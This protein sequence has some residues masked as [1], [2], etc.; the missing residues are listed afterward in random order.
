MQSS[1]HFK[2]LGSKWGPSQ[3]KGTSGGIVTFSFPTQNIEG[4]EHEFDSFMSDPIFQA[5]VMDGFSAW[6]N[7]ANIKFLE[8]PDSE[9]IDIRIGWKDIDGENGILGAATLPSAGPLESVTIALDQNEEWFVGGDAPADKLDFSAVIT[10]EIGHAIGVDHPDFSGTLMS[11]GYNPE[12]L[13]IQPDDQDA[14]VEIYGENTIVKSEV[15]RFFN[16]DAGG[17]FFTTDLLEKEIVPTVTNFTP[18]GVGFRAI[19]LDLGNATGAVPVHRFYNSERGSHFFTINEIERQSVASLEEFEYEGVGF[20]AFA[21]K[22]SAMVP[23]FRFFDSVNGGH[24]FT[25]N[26]LEKEGIQTSLP[27]LVFEGEAFFAFL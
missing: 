11:A 13:T 26:S 2:L 20:G 6:E 19:S 12:I 27:E 22:T 5:E 16:P 15:Y 3:L 17:H 10:H 24:F 23:V 8:L 14:V 25:A 1:F 18:E 9:A 21:I 7:L 4:H